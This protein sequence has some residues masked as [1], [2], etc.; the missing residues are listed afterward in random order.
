MELTFSLLMVLGALL[1]GAISPG[2][3]FV[4]VARTSMAASRV[5]GFATAIGMGL[6]GMVFSV[7]VLLGLQ[8]AIATVPW[9][10]FALKLAGG[11]YL[12]YIAVRIWRGAKEPIVVPASR[13]GMRS[14]AKKSLLRG[15][16]TQLSNPKTAV[17][18]GSVFAALLPRNLPNGATVML[19]LLVFLVE[20]GWYSI[21]A[22][23]LSAES[24]RNAY[25]RS[26]THV[27][28][29]AGGVMGL[30]GLKLIAAAR[31]AS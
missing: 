26:K 21:V 16:F 15:L 12:A 18:Y 28:R 30:L 29:I 17:V 7:L 27:D 14:S 25:L 24:S 3:S 4:L 23:A 5:D 6:G 19:P 1:L 10:Y 13:E 31:P 20:A 9:F 22:L 2:P 11:L 8:A